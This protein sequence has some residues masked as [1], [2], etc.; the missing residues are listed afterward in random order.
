MRSAFGSRLS[1]DFFFTSV[2]WAEAA[3]T[4][5]ENAP[6]V[7]WWAYAPLTSRAFSVGHSADYWTIAVLVS[8]FGSIEPQSTSLPPS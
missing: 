2:L 5:P 6:D 4:V 8:G 7:G 3:S 1:E